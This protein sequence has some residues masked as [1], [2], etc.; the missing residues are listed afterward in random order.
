MPYESL[1]RTT[2][3]RKYAIDEL[4]DC[5]KQLKSAAHPP[6]TP[7]EDVVDRLKGCVRQLQRLKRKLD[8]ASVVEREESQ[9]CKARLEH[10]HT[11]GPPSRDQH[12]AWNRKRIDRI[13]VDYM[14]RSGYLES[15]A[16]LVQRAHLTDLVDLH[17]FLGADH[18]LQSLKQ[19]KCSDALAWCAQH[20]TRLRKAKSPLEFQLR[21]QEYV[22]LVRSQDL[23]QAITYARQYLA[24]WAEQYPKQVQRLAALLAFKP[25]TTCLSYASLFEDQRWSTLLSLFKSELYRLHSLPPAS[26]LQI[27]LQAG[28]SALKTP[29]S[30]SVALDGQK[31]KPGSKDPLHVAAFRHLASDLPF[32]KHVHSKLICA[33][34]GEVMTEH[35]P[36]MALPNGYTYSKGGLE[37]MAAANGGVVTCPHTGASYQLSDLRRVFIM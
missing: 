33:L 27:H 6:S 18:V 15:A 28:L 32:A 16:K 10:L 8:D 2:R 31:G 14:L 24:P 17:V 20:A 11:L 29:Q 34:T 23:R 36:P 12:I 9:R 22:E 5:I 3:E 26:S 37:A 21:M 35:N 13:I 19:K 7:P 30:Y 25:D 1:K 4:K